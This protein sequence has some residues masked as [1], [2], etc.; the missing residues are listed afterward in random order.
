M[1][2]TSFFRF[3]AAAPAL[4]LLLGLASRSAAAPPKAADPRPALASATAKLKSH[5]PDQIAAALLEVRPLRKDAA[6]LVPMV[7]NLL[8]EGLPA[9][10]AEPALQFLSDQDAADAAPVVAT[11][12]SHRL[13]SVRRAATKALGHM[14]SPAS[15]TALRKLLAD[16]DS[17]VRG[18]A[19]SS[20]GA[21]R[22]R[23]ALADLET[24]LDQRVFEAAGAIGQIC[25]KEECKPLLDRLGK[26]PFDVIT[27]GLNILLY[28]PKAEV[29][30]KFKVQVVEHVRE[31]GTLE[32]H[33]FLEDVSK[34]KGLS[35]ELKTAVDDAVRA[36]GGSP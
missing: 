25:E 3:A 30:E 12:A 32:A 14:K 2:R 34:S 23:A 5:E 27:G 6:S 7:K 22:T 8:E 28:R 9:S 18:A 36:T 19:A 11:Y 16:Q 20:L 13:T 10:A 15:A 21:L 31:L 33:K 4:T 35:P 1:R 26:L 24:A 17:G 29:P